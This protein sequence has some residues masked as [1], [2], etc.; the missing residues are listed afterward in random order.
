M[1]EDNRTYHLEIFHLP[2]R[3]N[4]AELA[5]S[6]R[7]MRNTHRLFSYTGY[8]F[9]REPTIAAT[10]VAHNH[11]V[12]IQSCAQ[13]GKSVLL[14][15]VIHWIA[16]Y[17]K[18]NI[19]YIAD[20][21][22][23]ALRMSTTRFKNFLEDIGLDTIRQVDASVG[24]SKSKSAA[25]ISLGGGAHLIIGSS[26]S[27]SDLASTSARYILGD[28]L[29]RWETLKG[30]GN[31]LD[32]VTQRQLQAGRGMRVLVSTP[33][34]ENCLITQEYLLGTQE[35]WGCLCGACGK[36]FSV[37][38]S[39]ID[40][41]DTSPTYT[42]PHCGEVFTE[43]QIAGFTHCYGAPLNS[44]PIMDDKGRL[45]RSFSITAPNCPS[46]YSWFYL[47]EL[48]RAALQKGEASMQSFYNTRIG[49]PWTPP[50]EIRVDAVELMRASTLKYNDDTLPRDAE[51]LC[52][53]IDTHDSALYYCLWAFDKNIRLAYAITAHIIA[54]DIENDPEPLRE[55]TELMNRV[56][57][58]VDGVQ[59]R[60]HFAC[61]DAGGHKTQSV[62]LF[63]QVNPRVKPVRGW[64]STQRKS[65][66]DPLLRREFPMLCSR[67]KTKIKVLEVSS[68]HGKDLF[69]EWAKLT[70]AGDQRICANL[71]NC[72]R[73]NFFRS[74]CSEVKI[75]GKWTAL[76]GSHTPN[77]A[78]DCFVYA[79]SAAHYYRENF[80]LTG[81][82]PEYLAQQN[83]GKVEPSSPAPVIEE[84]ESKTPSET[85]PQPNQK[86]KIKPSID[87]SE[88]QAKTFKNAADWYPKHKVH[89]F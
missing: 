45:Y 72:F 47:K 79:T 4:G 61:M 66:P 59:I 53:G 73:E 71:K 9:F 51:F 86:P 64:D 34:D 40:W 42:C 36:H 65:G 31:P 23:T 52:A 82:D 76:K 89:R 26:K 38:W 6:S 18:S 48:E 25:L 17:D 41:N 63:S 35:V 37:I 69:L 24:D 33:T 57:T 13:I 8:E 32:L 12:C 55:L 50:Q 5:E 62:L 28:E 74:L 83:T 49:V 81:R 68:G 10:D 11:T 44:D 15:N 84:R 30:E 60:P 7:Y 56:Y 87:I 88:E 2:P 16:K 27:A 14:E 67:L 80:A 54:G 75:N 39:R 70:L 19:I 21:A 20:T 85:Q 22:K 58:R 46:V 29:A 77:E 1:N 43:S 3:M 78:L